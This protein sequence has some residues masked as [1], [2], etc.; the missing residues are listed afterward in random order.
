M[1]IKDIM[2]SQELDQHSEILTIE[3]NGFILLT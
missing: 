3:A 1:P 2:T